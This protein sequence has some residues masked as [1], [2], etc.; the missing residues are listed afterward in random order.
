MAGVY[1]VYQ[2][3]I[4]A[5]ALGAILATRPEIKLL[6]ATDQPDIAAAQIQALAPHVILLEEI[7]DGQ[8]KADL[9]RILTSTITS[10]RLITLRLDHDGM[11][12]WSG[13]W[14]QT[15][16]SGDLVE[17]ILSAREGQA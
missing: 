10:R 7:I 9:A 2:N 12:V 3:R 1:L 17:A 14:Q 13:K 8:I 15:A 4:F 16:R 6:G 5:D 11:H